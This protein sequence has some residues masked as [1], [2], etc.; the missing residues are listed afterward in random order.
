MAWLAVMVCLKIECTWHEGDR[1]IV[2]GAALAP[3]VCHC[4]CLLFAGDHIQRFPCAILA[5]VDADNS[6][7]QVTILTYEINEL[8]S[9][10][11][12]SE[13][14]RAANSRHGRRVS[15]TRSGLVAGIPNSHHI[16]IFPRFTVSRGV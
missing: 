9:P 14:G 7:T 11:E 10:H 3:R 13:W 2:R 15:C 12:W 6:V 1:A 5:L 4:V 8:A 16:A